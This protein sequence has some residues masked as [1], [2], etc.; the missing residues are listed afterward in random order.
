MKELKYG[1]VREN[2]ITLVGLIITV[3]VMLIIAGVSI[4]NGIE[5]LDSTRLKGFYTQLEIVQKRVDDIA[6]TNEKYVDRDGQEV[7]IKEKGQ[8][9]TQNQKD[10]LRNILQVEGISINNINIEEF[11]YFKIQDI[12]DILDLREIEYDLFIN[13]EDRIIIAEDGITIEDK[14]YYA[15]KNSMYFVET[16]I[17]KNNIDVGKLKYSTPTKYTKDSYR[18]TIIPDNIMGELKGSEYV[19]YK[20]T[21]TKYW[22]TSY[23]NEIIMQKDVEYNIK[24]F[25]SDKSIEK[26]IKID[27]KKDEEGNFVEDE[28]GKKILTIIEIKKEQ[29]SEES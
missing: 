15:L 12:E 18:V 14:T 19:K 8:S 7:D 23:N 16:D 20:N 25:Y 21:N 24:Y 27:Y 17:S 26:I 10:T 9:L 3:V 2:G 22:E 4:Y 28:E 29:E 5:S 1:L 13:F 11:K 6:A